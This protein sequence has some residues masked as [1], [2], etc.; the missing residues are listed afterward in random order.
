MAHMEIAVVGAGAAGCM[1]AG[2][3]GKL[4]PQA[5]ITVYEGGNRPLAKVA[6]TGG[7]RCNLTN[8]FAEVKSTESVYPRGARLM[9]RMLN[10]FSHQAVCRWFEQQGVR[11]TTQPDGCVFPASQDAMQVVRTLLQQ[12]D[13]G[14]VVLRTGY[15]LNRLSRTADQYTLEFANG[16][17]AQADMVLLTLGGCKDS[18]LATM[19]EPLQIAIAPTM[20]SLYGLRTTPDAI[21]QLAGTIVEQAGAGIEGT[22]IRTQGTLLI[23]HQG[24]SGPVILK[25]TAFGAAHLH[26]CQYQCNIFIN[27]MGDQSAQEVAALLATMASHHA[28]AQL[29]TIHPPELTSRLWVYLLD[30]CGISPT[31]RWAQLQPTTLRRMAERLT[32]HSLCTCGRSLH[33]QEFVTAG[34]VALNQINPSTLEHRKH[35]NLYFAGEVLDV[36]GITG[37]FNLQA[38][39]SMGYVAAKQMAQR[40][41]EATACPDGGLPDAL[42]KASTP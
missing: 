29:G 25:L 22:R 13:K 9:R 11:L 30:H 3:L 7:G 2:L 1:A 12:M 21:T 6:I 23:T 40:V 36:D 14:G 19:L 18:R 35:P 15:R 26:Q 4:A 38:A 27:W 39:W 41:S 34:G 20:P 37:G 42:S 33:K 32:H 5:Q 16:H 17:T 31:T 24:V 28:N 8:S 10:E